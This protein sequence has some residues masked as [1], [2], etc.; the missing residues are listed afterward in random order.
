ME[1]GIQS[2]RYK[3]VIWPRNN[4]R[5]S[6]VRQCF[7]IYKSNNVNIIYWMGPQ[8]EWAVEN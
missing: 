6:G 8:A 1:G 4:W 7:L 5:S 2:W 3:A